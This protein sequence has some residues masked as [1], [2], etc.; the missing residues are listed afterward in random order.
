MN[1]VFFLFD[2]LTIY[3]IQPNRK[4]VAA[5]L[6]DILVIQGDG[7]AHWGTKLKKI[8]RRGKSSDK[9]IVQ[10]RHPPHVLF[11]GSEIILAS[12]SDELIRSRH[13]V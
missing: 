7:A 4:P 10:E 1:I 6:Q 2:T 8:C 11:M 12:N 3:L 5:G 13:F 9:K